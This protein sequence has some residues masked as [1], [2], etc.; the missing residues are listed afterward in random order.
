MNS[1]LRRFQQDG[2]S[3]EQINSK[4]FA[5]LSQ[6]SRAIYNYLQRGKELA[7]NL[8]YEPIET[9]SEIS[10]K[11]YSFS[12]RQRVF[13]KPGEL[14]RITHK[15]DIPRKFSGCFFKTKVSGIEFFR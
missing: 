1:A 7:S 10:A 8:E 2:F 4:A 6:K 9:S 14:S 15:Q 13:L 12:F 11:P 5:E 3:D